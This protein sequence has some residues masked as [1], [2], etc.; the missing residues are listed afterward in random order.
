MIVNGYKIGF[1]SEQQNLITCSK[2][3]QSAPIPYDVMLYLSLS[4][5]KWSF[6][7][8]TFC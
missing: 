3:V 8:K 2:E 4:S 7:I 5:K 6:F 1:A